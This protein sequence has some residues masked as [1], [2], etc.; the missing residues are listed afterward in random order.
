MPVTV[1]QYQA[2]IAEIRIGKHVGTSIYFHRECVPELPLPIAE[3]AEKATTLSE[4]V[5]FE[6]NV[7]KFDVRAPLISL[8]HY[9]AFFE[10]AF[11]SLTVSASWDLSTD[12]LN[13]RDYRDPNNR[14]IL[15]RKE[16]LLP[17]GHERVDEF[18]S[19]TEI[20]EQLGLFSDR[21][22]IGRQGFWLQ[23]LNERRIRL[24]G[25]TFYRPDGRRIEY[26]SQKG[27]VLR[28]R[29]A[30]KRNKLSLPVQMLYKHEM[31][32]ENTTFFDFGCGRGDDI[33][34][35][36]E[37]GVVAAGW[38]PYYQPGAPKESADIVNL[39][40]VINVIEKPDERVTVISEAFSYAKQLLNVSALVG[41]NTYSSNVQPYGDGV[42][43]SAGTFQKYFQPNELVELITQSTGSQPVPVAPGIL[44]V[45]KDEALEQTFLARRISRRS[46]GSVR[47]YVRSV[48]ELTETA[49]GQAERYWHYC[50]E[51]GRP[52]E[53]DEIDGCDDLF[54]AL[55]SIKQLFEVIAKTKEEAPFDE[56]RSRRRDELLVDFSLA[57]FGKRVFFK[58]FENSLKRDIRFHFGTYSH[59]VEQASELLYSISDIDALLAACVDASDSGVGFLLDDHSLQLHKALIE[60][61]SPILR[62]YIGCAGILY[63]DWTRSDLVKVHIQSGK[64][65]FMGYDDFD[66][67]PVPELLE[68]IKVKMWERRVDFFYYVE[69]YAPTPLFMKSLFID[70]TFDCYEEQSMFDKAL[71]KTRLFDFMRDRVT[72]AQFYDALE[73]ARLCVR[74]YELARTS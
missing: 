63:G 73:Q 11:P 48:E 42:L 49:Q 70:E 56:A 68:R 71:M 15:H 20:A 13:L 14:P 29:T 44:F 34:Q 30:L 58:Y 4:K 55:P 45:F 8:L 17:A 9:P 12:Y 50:L 1:D 37:L 31:L 36:T 60:R 46:H 69:Q 52:V 74:G 43:T 3:L 16:L 25:H 72:K 59:A 23:L 57:Q 6:F 22:R 7:Y 35:L 5:G 54:A 65:S 40:Y 18:A 38:D 51:L 27:Q 61:L 64:V 28:Y 19:L 33:R 26:V 41:P 53:K 10:Q 21:R 32:S 47:S 2:H 24:Q 67:R 39:G 62:V 66:G